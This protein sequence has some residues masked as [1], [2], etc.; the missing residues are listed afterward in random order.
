M[1]NV[2]MTVIICNNFVY[3]M[4]GGQVR[5][6]PRLLHYGYDPRGNLVPPA[7]LGGILKHSNAPFVVRTT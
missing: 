3:G 4:T 1:L 2:K 5:G 6:S 7:D